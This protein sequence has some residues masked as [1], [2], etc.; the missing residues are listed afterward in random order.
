MKRR[1]GRRGSIAVE[2]AVIAPVMIAAAI[3]LIQVAAAIRIQLEVNRSAWVLA[4]LI[5]QEADVTT[6]ELGDFAV[7]AQDCY[8]FKVGTLVMSAASVNF[9]TAN[10]TG[11]VAWD[12]SSVSAAN[13][14]AMPA[15]T[16]TSA[17]KLTTGAGNDSVIVVRTSATFTVPFPVLPFIK[18]PTSF[19][20]TDVVYARPRLG[21]VVTLN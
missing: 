18:L 14:L 3:G 6:A 4:N 1:S 5:S 15:A 2:F 20:F 16:V 8:D 17:A 7:A 12:A 9:T 10:P 13:Y 11:A 19:T 21:Y